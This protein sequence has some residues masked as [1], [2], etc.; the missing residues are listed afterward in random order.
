MENEDLKIEQT[1]ETTNE[2]QINELN[3]EE[4]NNQEEQPKEEIRETTSEDQPIETN[5]ESTEPIQSE[6]TP[7]NANVEENKPVE[8]NTPVEQP[9]EPNNIQ[10]P[11]KGAPVG[12]IIGIVVGVLVFIVILVLLLSRMFVTPKEVVNN[13]VSSVFKQAR[14][15][16]KTTQSN[17]LQYDL[18]K[19]SL[20]ITGDLTID[21]NYK[22][23][24]IDLTKLKN[25]QLNYTGVIDKKGNEASGGFALTKS[26]KDFLKAN[27]Y[28]DGNKA[29]FELGDLFNKT[30]N[31]KLD[32]EI[33]DLD[34]ST[35]TNI[36]DIDRL[37]QKTEV[38]VKNIIK[39]DNI[40]QTI[41][42]KEFNG[43]KSKYTKVEYIFNPDDFETKLL[44]AYLNDDEAIKLI[45]SISQKEDNK[46][47]EDFNRTI[48]SNKNYRSETKETINIYLQGVMKKAVAYELVSNNES[49]LIFN[50]NKDYRITL[51]ENNKEL[52][53]G[54]YNTKT[55]T[56]NL[57]NNDGFSLNA[58]FKNDKITADLNIEDNDMKLNV[59]AV[60]NNK[61]K[62]STQT[63]ETTLKLDYSEGRNNISATVTS[64]MKIEKNKKVSTIKTT[65]TVNVDDISNTELEDIY[66]KLLDK[67]NELEKDIM[68]NSTGDLTQFKK[69]I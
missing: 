10:P 25:Y 48:S 6:P 51:T 60:I 7:E 3:I 57:K 28:I 35:K 24:D 53:S 68:P 46:V 9:T 39:N 22:D 13:G 33:K 32:K 5:T 52:L 15:L 27:A 42:E 37:L 2:E 61:V 21:S 58:T 16:L 49:L 47:R 8:E 34:L 26:N 54:D 31:T 40:T 23:K 62:S 12:L 63:N 50:E 67:M 30:L 29:Y 66:T 65:P 36:Q 20:G 38:I 59:N 11:K 4:E 1:N 17:I 45:A 55:K 43:K 18:D 19:D 44:E 69:I 56:L 41:E 64:R 14:T